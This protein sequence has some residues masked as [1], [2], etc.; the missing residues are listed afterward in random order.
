M[1]FV[2]A[3]EVTTIPSGNVQII[4]EPAV[5]GN[6]MRLMNGPAVVNVGAADHAESS[7]AVAAGASG[8]NAC[9]NVDVDDVPPAVARARTNWGAVVGAVSTKIPISQIRV[10]RV[11]DRSC[12]ITVLGVATPAFELPTS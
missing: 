11:G 9:P 10:R 6:A 4:P 12:H 3:V 5:T 2:V 1:R 8:C 7:V